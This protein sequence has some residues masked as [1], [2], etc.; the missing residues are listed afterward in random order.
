[1]AKM[2]LSE[3]IGQ[4]GSMARQLGVSRTDCPYRDSTH[5]QYWVNGWDSNLPIA[6]KPNIGTPNDN[7]VNDAIQFPRLISELSAAGVF[8][9]NVVEELKDSMDL[10][11]GLIYQI[12]ERADKVW[13]DIKART[14]PPLQ[15]G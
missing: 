15:E 6:S 9:L 3:A 13:E 5:A 8:T 12:V 4:H 11:E 14:S 1:M 10:S 2:K 7:F